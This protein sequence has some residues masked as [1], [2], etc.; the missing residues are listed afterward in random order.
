MI[1]SFICCTEMNLPESLL[2]E[3]ITD[4]KSIMRPPNMKGNFSLE[5]HVL[6]FVFDNRLRRICR[7]AGKDPFIFYLIILIKIRTHALRDGV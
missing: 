7:P 6:T 2:L 4:T 5:K 1:L 3:N